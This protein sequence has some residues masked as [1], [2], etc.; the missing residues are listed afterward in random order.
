M[1][2]QNC[3]TSNIIW[4]AIKTSIWKLFMIMLKIENYFVSNIITFLLKDIQKNNQFHV[5]WWGA[6][7]IIISLTMYTNWDGNFY[8]EDMIEMTN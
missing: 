8:S 7:I 2:K 4:I 1:I 6:Q 3:L 5:E